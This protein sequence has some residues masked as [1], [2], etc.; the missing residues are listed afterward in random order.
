MNPSEI[1]SR[2]TLTR[3]QRNMALAQPIARLSLE[4]R[5]IF[6][7]DPAI[8]ECCSACNFGRLYMMV[9]LSGR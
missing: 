3:Q 6:R 5:V 7:D 4:R 8:S 1:S 2:E 9:T